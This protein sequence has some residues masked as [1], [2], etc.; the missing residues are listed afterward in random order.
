MD[1]KRKHKRIERSFM[2][3]FRTISFV[4]IG[5]CF[6]KWDIVTVRNLS[7]GGMLFNY[8]NNIELGTQVNFRII[9]PLSA[10]AICCIGK[11]IRNNKPSV[12]PNT[13][14]SLVAAEFEKIKKKDRDL[15]DAVADEVRR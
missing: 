9:F 14:I 4:F 10:H 11:I 5:R 8:Y 13:R 15:I 7:A 1:E 2:S 3:W 12:N 6:S